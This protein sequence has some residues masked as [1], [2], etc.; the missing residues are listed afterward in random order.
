M[1]PHRQALLDLLD[2]VADGLESR[3]AMVR[4]HGDAERRVP[5]SQLPDAVD[6]GDRPQARPPRCAIPR[7]VSPSRPF[8]TQFA[9]K[10]F[11]ACPAA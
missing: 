11:P 8:G 1:L 7:R 10:R 9:A 3:R 2:D 6:D 5:N 4:A